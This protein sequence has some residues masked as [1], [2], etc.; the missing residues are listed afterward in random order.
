MINLFQMLQQ[1]VNPKQL[2]MSMMQQRPDIQQALRQVQNSAG[3][4]SYKDIC[5]QMA[6]RQ[7]IP[8]EQLTQLYNQFSRK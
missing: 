8:Q 6:Q 5:M 4:A 3:G 1:S 7:G 2:F